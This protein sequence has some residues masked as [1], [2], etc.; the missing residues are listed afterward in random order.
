MMNPILIHNQL[1][2]LDEKLKPCAVLSR[3]DNR[4][5]D[6]TI[7]VKQMF[8]KIL[9][10]MDPPEIIDVEEVNGDGVQ[11]QDEREA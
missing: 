9:A 3:A 6:V 10:C 1:T 8:A 7:D 2:R 5:T 11:H 4:I